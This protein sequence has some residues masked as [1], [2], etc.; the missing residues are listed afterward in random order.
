MKKNKSISNLPQTGKVL[1]IASLLA[2]CSVSGAWCEEKWKAAFN[3]ICSKVD[4]S[5]TLSTPELTELIVRLDKLSPEIQAS[6]DPSKK[7]YLQRL[8]KCRS[9]YEFMIET[10]KEDG[11]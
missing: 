10:K 2:I 11:K 8:K 7:I 9:M 1:A 4:A 5:G 3:D 6:G